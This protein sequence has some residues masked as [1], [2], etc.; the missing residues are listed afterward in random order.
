MLRLEHLNLVVRDMQETLAFYQAAMPHWRVRCEGEGTWNGVPRRWLHFGDDF[1]YIAFGDNGTGQNRNLA[2]Y[3]LGLAHFA[4]EVSDLDML[5]EQLARAGFQPDSPGNKDPYRRNVYFIDPNG[6]E[7]E[8][9]Q[10]LS[11]DPEQ[12]NLTQ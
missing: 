7:V 11:D 10:Y 9:V 2:G 8:F 1:T 6:F 5:T 4:F 3:E 12:R